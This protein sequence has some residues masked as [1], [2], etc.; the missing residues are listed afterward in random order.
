MLTEHWVYP[1]EKV[2]LDSCLTTV[3]EIETRQ[4]TELIVKWKT[5]EFLEDKVGEYLCDLEVGKSSFNKTR[6]ILSV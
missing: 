5:T 2:T 1:P 4:I 3:W 6:G